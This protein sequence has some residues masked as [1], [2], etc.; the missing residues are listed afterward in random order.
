LR[1][2]FDALKDKDKTVRAQAARALGRIGPAA[3][4]AVP[5]LT[6]MSRESD[7]I[8]AKE[9]REALQGIGP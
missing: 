8:V 1:A 2:L 9:A 7:V 5:A 3:R 6:A 4:E